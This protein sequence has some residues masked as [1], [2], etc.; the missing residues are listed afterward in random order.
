LSTPYSIRA[1]AGSIVKYDMQVDMISQPHGYYHLVVDGQL[2]LR[3]RCKRT[4][5]YYY[6]QAQQHS[7]SSSRFVI[8]CGQPFTH[9]SSSSSR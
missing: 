9:V 5:E 6:A 8:V 1:T 7:S 3:T 2:L 4:V